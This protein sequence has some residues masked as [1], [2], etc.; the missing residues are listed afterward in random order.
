[1]TIEC[2]CKKEWIQLVRGDNWK[3]QAE[4]GIERD[5]WWIFQRGSSRENHEAEKRTSL[6]EGS[7]PSS[8]DTSRIFVSQKKKR[9]NRCSISRTTST[10]V[11]RCFLTW[12]R[13]VGIVCRCGMFISWRIVEWCSINL[14]AVLKIRV[15]NVQ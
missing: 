10:L 4:K 8:K 3:G 7:W 5:G 1:M 13:N 9:G 12:P 15:Q 11:S 2:R 14:V 6:W